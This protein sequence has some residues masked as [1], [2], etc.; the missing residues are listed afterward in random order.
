MR[1]TE[2]GFSRGLAGESA[3]DLL[4]RVGPTVRLDVGIRSRAPAGATPDLL[5]KRV[6]ALI[7]TGAGSECIDNALA[8]EL[9][10]PVHDTGEIGGVG[11]RHRTFIYRAR[12]CT[13]PP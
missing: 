11:G 9:R 8:E 2:A 13:S 4:L 10:L 6:L 12:G 3:A 5:K 1:S 7:D